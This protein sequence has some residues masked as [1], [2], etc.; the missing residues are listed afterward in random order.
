MQHDLRR[1][2]SK[3]EMNQGTAPNSY[4]S[5]ATINVDPKITTEAGDRRNAFYEVN[6]T[7]TRARNLT[8]RR[9]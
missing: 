2:R 7:R 5:K 8:R 4:P 9:L 6:V 1:L 3:T